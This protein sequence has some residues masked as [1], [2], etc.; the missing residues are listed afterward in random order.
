MYYFTK[1]KKNDRYKNHKKTNQEILSLCSDLRVLGKSDFKALLKWRIEMR[2]YKKEISEKNDINKEENPVLTEEQEKEDEEQNLTKELDLKI[3]ELNKKNK[4]RKKKEKEKKKKLQ[5]KIELN[6]I[7]P[8]DKWDMEND[9]ELFSLNNIKKYSDLE[10]IIDV[11]IPEINLE[12]NEKKE[13]ELD[14]KLKEDDLLNDEEKYNEEIENILDQMYEQY[15]EKSSGKSKKK[16]LLQLKS[17]E[18]PPYKKQLISNDYN[19][20][21]NLSEDISYE[22]KEE[23][24]PLIIKD[25]EISTTKQTK[26][27]FSQN[28]FNEIE[29]NEDEEDEEKICQLKKNL[30]ENDIKINKIEKNE[31]S[32]KKEEKKKKNKIKK[33]KDE[34]NFEEV[35]IQ[36]IDELDDEERKKLLALGTMMKNDKELREEIIDRAYNRYAFNDVDI[37]SWFFDEENEHNKPQLP[38]TKEMIQEIK[39]KLIEINARPIKKVM[40]AKARKKQKLN[41]KLKKLKNQVQTIMDSTDLNSINKSKA[42]EKLYKKTKIKKKTEKNYVVSKKMW[43]GHIPRGVK[44]NGIKTKLV[45]PRMKKDLRSSKLKEKKKGKK[46]TRN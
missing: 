1:L 23:N 32:D 19:Y 34:N 43:N 40:E 31:H 27:W 5:Q 6:M 41:K 9:Y 36:Q 33:I 15:L 38:V 7:L 24:N 44:K 3:E 28:I 18:E 46:R 22:E 16:K 14:N 8:D 11:P 42:L 29:D 35:P 2:E 37:P 45:D 21:P 17:S 4:K 39:K 25:T 30:Q 10:K 12:E 20:I 26:M 13:K